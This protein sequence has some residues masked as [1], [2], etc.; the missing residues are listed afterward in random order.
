ML[1]FG[2]KLR[3][4]PSYSN[5]A[6]R[7]GSIIKVI[8]TKDFESRGVAGEL[9]EVKAGYARNFLIPRKIAGI[10]VSFPNCSYPMKFGIDDYQYLKYTNLNITY[11]CHSYSCEMLD[12][13]IELNFATVKFPTLLGRIWDMIVQLAILN[14]FYSFFVIDSKNE[15]FVAQFIDYSKCYKDRRHGR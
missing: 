12:L 4:I 15:Y 7:W 9:I 14:E 5:I 3:R 10:I 2:I 1:S 6:C 13:S 11:N 8:L